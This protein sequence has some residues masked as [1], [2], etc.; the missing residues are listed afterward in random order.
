MR[1]PLSLLLFSCSFSRGFSFMWDLLGGGAFCR[2]FCC[3]R[4]GF[5][6]CW[7]SGCSSTRLAPGAHAGG[8]GPVTVGI[9]SFFTDSS[10]WRSRVARRRG[11]G[12]GVRRYD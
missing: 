10:C 8:G 7:G 12:G 4:D 5:C 9:F 1:P 2:A 3:W 11:R 6:L